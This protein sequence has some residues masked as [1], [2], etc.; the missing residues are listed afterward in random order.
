M[1]DDAKWDKSSNEEEEKRHLKP[2]KLSQEDVYLRFTTVQN[3]S[4]K[5]RK[6]CTQRKYNLETDNKPKPTIYNTKCSEKADI[7]LEKKEKEKMEE[8][9]KVLERSEQRKKKKKIVLCEA[10]EPKCTVPCLY[11]IVH[12]ECVIKLIMNP[13][14]NGLII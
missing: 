14:L 13:M 6:E 4:Y 9:K 3:K 8:E 11:V 12:Y 10:A 2:V 5:L 1:S 7:K